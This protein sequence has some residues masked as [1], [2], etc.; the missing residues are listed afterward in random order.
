MLLAASSFAGVITFTHT[1]LGSGTIGTTTFTDAAFTITDIGDT[2]NRTS[3][4]GGYY[5]NDTSA[6][7]AIAGI[8]TLGFVTLTHTFVN[9]TNQIV[10]FSWAT[11]LDLFD[12]PESASFATWDMLSSIGPI[13]GT[14][15]LMQWTASPV[16]TSGGVLVFSD[17]SSRSVFTAT[18]A[19]E[20]STFLPI[21]IIG[22]AAM[23][24]R[25]GR[26]RGRAA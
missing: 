9:N 8:G 7:I 19:P 22:M 15:S 13:S 3:F 6:S 4:S 14:G 17:G 23:L 1:G 16:V 10:G 24:V 5:I 12:G 2:A 26:R 25:A 20:P 11:G 18:T 21:G